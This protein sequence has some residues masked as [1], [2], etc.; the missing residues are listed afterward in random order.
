MNIAII[1]SGIVG[2][3]TG[4]GL[5]SNG[6]KVIFHD[7]NRDKLLNL[8]NSGY[9]ATDNLEEAVSNSKVV[10]VCVPTPTV[11]NKIDLSHIQE[12]AKN[13]GK[14]LQKNKKYAVIVFRS[15]IPPQTTRTK[16]VPSLEISSHL[17]AGK[18]FGICTNPEFLREKSPLEDFLNPS[19]IVIGELDKKSGNILE[20]IY[21]TFKCPLIRTDLDTAEMIKYVSNMYLAAKISF[22]NEIY[23]ICK[24]LGLN[25]RIISETASLDP[26]I[27]KYGV[28]GGKPFGG[29]CLPKD[30][31]AF[32]DFANSKGLNFT[33]LQ[34]IAEVNQEMNSYCSMSHELQMPR[35]EYVDLSS[36]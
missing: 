3:A 29:M 15:T 10:F 16:L 24:K 6:N 8:K 18:D 36:N 20:K 34:A 23:L 19:R 14:A 12:C 11:K 26:R 25:A 32:I 4:M 1:G 5:A 27:G 28:I 22:F 9:E 30:L 13:I 35:E 21:T 31:A 7:I 33:L 2:Q 17:S